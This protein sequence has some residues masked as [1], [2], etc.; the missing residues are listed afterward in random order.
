MVWE[1]SAVIVCI[2]AVLHASYIEKKYTAMINQLNVNVGIGDEDLDNNQNN[3]DVEE[4]FENNMFEHVWLITK[5][6]TRRSSSRRMIVID[7]ICFIGIMFLGSLNPPTI[8][9][10]MFFVLCLAPTYMFLYHLNN[11]NRSVKR[12]GCVWNGL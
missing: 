9:G 2:M 4:S 8:T 7:V 12:R 11:V 1:I 5:A 3:D 6:E 10:A